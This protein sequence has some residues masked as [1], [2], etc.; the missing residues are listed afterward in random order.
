[1]LL[2][3][4]VLVNPQFITAIGTEVIFAALLT[5]ET[6]SHREIHSNCFGFLCGTV[7]LW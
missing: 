4:C 6:Q 3:N 2:V 5:T 7:P 1:M